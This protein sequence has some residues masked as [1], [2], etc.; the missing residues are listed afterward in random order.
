M[1]M[2]GYQAGAS[3]LDEDLTPF[4]E[5]LEMF[6]EGYVVELH[7]ERRLVGLRQWRHCDGSRRTLAAHQLRSAPFRWDEPLRRLEGVEFV[8][9][10][11]NHQG[12]QIMKGTTDVEAAW[13]F[14]GGSAGLR[15][16]VSSCP[17]ASL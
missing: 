17:P 11:A 15:A 6:Y 4:G 10:P 8:H 16:P 5:I 9:I 2:S 3:L 12:F 1:V 13:K 7:Q 14:M